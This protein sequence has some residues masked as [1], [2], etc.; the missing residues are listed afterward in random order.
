MDRAAGREALA[1]RYRRFAAEE[2]RG[3]SPLYVA[4]AEH[5]ADSPALLRFLSGFPP[6]MQQPNLFLAA[7]RHVAGT[8]SGPAALDEMLARHAPEI[9][10][11]MRTRTTQTNEPG[12]CAA[13]L[14]LLAALPGPLALLEVGTSA[15]LCLLPDKYGYDYGWVRIDAPDET[16]EIAPILTCRASAN[17]PLPR[18]L[19]TIAWRAGLDLAPRD[20]RS[21]EDMAWLE[22]LVWPEQ[23][24]RRARLRAAIAVARA[25]G[26]QVVRGDL[27]TDLAALASRAPADAKLVV[28]HT[29]VLA[30]VPSQEDRDAFA[31]R[32]RDL[33]ATWIS[34]EFPQ[35]FPSIAAK[36][37]GPHPK[38]M[39]LLSIDGE[40]AAWTM[41]HGQMLEWL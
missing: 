40:P 39:F 37:P 30:Y 8:P 2:A 15:G 33:G 7:V 26:P 4:L 28:Y 5:V 18:S 27:R 34:N 22:T 29:A 19:P 1:E 20:V 41:P 11:A 13:L 31:R 32:C 6:E 38:G 12:R 25:V 35:V 3:S 10:R 21:P 14:P 17:V 24:D 36:V 16:A 9:D 23:E